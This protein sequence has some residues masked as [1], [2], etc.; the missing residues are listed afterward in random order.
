MLEECEVQPF[1]GC[2]DLER[3]Q[4]FYEGTL[5]LEVVE[6]NGFALLV[7]GPNATVRVTQAPEV[8]PTGYT[9]LGWVVDD[10]ERAVDDLAGRG[11]VFL[12]YPQMDQDG[13]L[14]WTAPGGDRVAW[15]HDP[16][17]NVLSVH[18]RG[19]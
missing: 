13:R 19:S 9:V 18:E 17:G 2:S 10:I 14:I 11:V 12:D 3:A 16:D 6:N 8:G 7:A 1:V 5:G 15:F 4:A